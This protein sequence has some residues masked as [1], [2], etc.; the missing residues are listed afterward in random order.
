MRPI[1]KT[2]A[3]SEHC[4]DFVAHGANHVPAEFLVRRRGG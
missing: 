2:I 3:K 4:A 1:A